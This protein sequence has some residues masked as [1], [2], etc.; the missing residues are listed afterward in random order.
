MTPPTKIQNSRIFESVS[1][2][3][4]AKVFTNSG[5]AILITDAQNRIVTANAAFTRLT[6]YAVEEVLGQ[7]PKILSSGNTPKEV[8]LQMWQ[9]LSERDAW[10]GELWDRRKT[11]EVYPKWLSINVIRDQHGQIT[12]YIGNFNDISERKASEE[13]FLRLAYHDA[14]TNLPNRLNLHERLEQ[15]ISLCKRDGHKFALMLID[16]D[17][18]KIINDTLGHHVGD[19]LLIEVARRLT[20]SV[21]ESDI[22]ARLGGDE[23][24]V[25]ITS[26]NSASDAAEVAGKIVE[27][28]SAPY[29]IAGNDLRTSPSI[30]ICL[31]PDDADEISMMLKSGDVAMYHAKAKGRGNY[32]F[33]TEGMNQAV[34]QRQSLEADLRTALERGQFV[35]HYQ[36]QLDLD[37]GKLTGV[38]ALM[39]WRHP[40]RGLVSPMEFIPVAEEMGLIVQLGSWVLRE[41]CMQLKRWQQEGLTNVR[42]SVNLSALQFLDK[43]LAEHIK[44]TLEETGLGPEYLDLEVTESMSMSS[45]GDTIAIMKIL[46]EHGM[47]L[48]IDDFG[49]GYSSLAYLKLFPIHTLKID[50]SF[51]TDIEIDTNDADICDVTVLLAHKMGLNVVAEGVETEAQLKFLLSIGCNRIQGF[52]ISKPLPAEEVVDFFKNYT[53]RSELGTVNLWDD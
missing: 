44:S 2:D 29:M 40:V 15:T 28:V 52:L 22:V 6:G 26:L 13:K 49:T 42:M 9:S 21:R 25:V 51:V 14:L 3:L 46:A 53:P 17:R 16:L 38:E 34:M 12:N 33:F 41:A 7:D 35:L 30:G 10:E 23:F 32:Q 37:S 8:Y 18:F 31:F 20:T 19:L 24:V 48:S 11:G 36:P 4:M 47:S 39:R 27:T 50:R 5:E 45:P 1:T 43:D